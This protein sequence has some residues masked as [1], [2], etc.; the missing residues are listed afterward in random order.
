[1]IHGI[2]TDIVHI[3]RFKKALD[4]WGDSLVERIFTPQEVAYSSKK[5]SPEQ[6]LAVRFAAKEAFFKAIGRRIGFREVE[7]VNDTDGRPYF[8]L[9]PQAF[10]L[11]LRTHLSLAHHGEY[12]I[13]QVIL[14][15]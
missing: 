13:A 9:Q 10:S 3:P 4:R 8:S 5:R 7:V 2:G 12:C 1:M 11:N 6:H 14:E 15:R